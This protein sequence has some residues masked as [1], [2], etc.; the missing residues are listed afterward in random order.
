[1]NSGNRF[2]NHFTASL[3]PLIGPYAAND[4]VFRIVITAGKRI[5]TPD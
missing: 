5:P 3:V 1:M 2:R 4:L